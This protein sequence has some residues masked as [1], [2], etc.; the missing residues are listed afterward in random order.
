MLAEDDQSKAS[1][2]NKLARTQLHRQNHRE[3]LQL[4]KEALETLGES[5]PQSPLRLQLRSWK[6]RVK[7]LVCSSLESF[8]L[9]LR[10][11]WP[12][13]LDYG[14]RSRGVL[15]LY[16]ELASLSQGE[17]DQLYRYALVQQT[18]WAYKLDDPLELLL[19][20]GRQGEHAAQYHR[21]FSLPN[22]KQEMESLVEDSSPKSRAAA[23]FFLGRVSF[24]CERWEQAKVYFERCVAATTSEQ[25]NSLHEAALQHLVR[26][27]RK[28]GDFA[29]ALDTASCLL[30]VYLRLGNPSRLSACCRH[31][32]LIYA[33][34]GD[35]QQAR[36]WGIKSL[37]V[38][39]SHP[40]HFSDLHLS[41]L[42]CYV[43]L[44]DLEFR[45]GNKDRARRYL[46]GAIRLQR[47]HHLPAVFLHDGMKLLRKIRGEEPL[48]E[49]SLH[50]KSREN[51]LPEIAYLYHEYTG[52]ERSSRMM[53]TLRAS[54]LSKNFLESELHD[55]RRKVQED[56]GELESL[57]PVG[58][59]STR[60][61]KG[62]LSMSFI[63]NIT[64]DFSDA[65]KAPWGYFFSD[66]LQD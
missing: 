4:L 15:H 60:W 14:E 20:L 57:F 32:A 42:R 33:S 40:L 37:D 22:W 21:F 66:E 17:D 46:G 61:G 30:E 26:V 43:L 10:R 34:F 24:L 5:L 36:R 16:R 8:G 64:T 50:R 11:L 49:N 65:S 52:E 9:P 28:D 53:P 7:H 55:F 56:S 29:K 12:S 23:D 45:R 19:A 54:R 13:T 58:A 38:L 47:E 3:S 41:Q 6:I 1:L 48:P 39:R 63:G 31:F 44:A 18:D 25:D 2:L 59:V 62:D 27:Y 51:T 35:L